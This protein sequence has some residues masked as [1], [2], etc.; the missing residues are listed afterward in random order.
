MIKKIKRDFNEE[1]QK[2]FVTSF[3]SY[4]NFNP[5]TDFI[6]DFDDE[7]MP[8]SRWYTQIEDYLFDAKFQA[9]E[10]ICKTDTE[11]TTTLADWMRNGEWESMTPAQMAEEWDEINSNN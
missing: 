10:R 1:E 2:I 5:L 7:V 3:Y 6:I 4:L 9:T 11:G 8:A